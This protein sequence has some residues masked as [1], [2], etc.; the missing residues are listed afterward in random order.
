MPNMT[1]L[2]RT[3]CLA[4]ALAAVVGCGKGNDAA[5]AVIDASGRH[6]V[7]KGYSSWVQQHWVEYRQLNG[8]SAAFSSQTSCSQCHGADLSGGNSRV[9]CF[10]AERRD[11]NGNTVSCHDNG[12]RTLGHPSSWSDPASAGFHAKGSFN[13]LAV[14]GSATLARECGPCHATGPGESSLGPAPSCLSTDPRF[15]IACHSSSPALASQGCVSCHGAPPAGPEG[16]APPNRLGAHPAHI[17]LGLMCGVCHD[18]AGSGTAR[19]ASGNGQ[20]FLNLSSG[21]QA[22][23][24]SFAYSGG[25]CSAVSCH[26]GQQTPIWSGGSIDPD[27]ECTSCHAAANQFNSYVSG[28]HDFHLDDP[29]GPRLTCTSCH[30]TEL[31]TGHF[32]GLATAAFETEPR[33]TLSATLNYAQNGRGEWSC[34]VACHFDINGDNPDPNRT[35]FVWK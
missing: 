30:S 19:H 21:Y 16:N 14:R 10:S 35:I 24:G 4:G 13:G 29:N 32:A 11:G 22:Q 5:P 26:G 6:A 33:H 27:R 18:G 34:T 20:A 9:S 28:E 23:S 1:A 31:M 8:G 7:A 25:K 3:I 17:V 2:I 15:G 12:D